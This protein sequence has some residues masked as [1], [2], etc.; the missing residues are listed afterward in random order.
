MN[1]PLRENIVSCVVRDANVKKRLPPLNS[2]ALILSTIVALLFL[3]LHPFNRY[4]HPNTYC[5]WCTEP[6]LCDRKFLFVI[7]SGRAGSTSLMT[8]LNAMPDVFVSGENNDTALIR[9]TFEKRAGRMCANLY[10]GKSSVACANTRRYELM[11]VQNWLWESN[12]PAAAYMRKRPS[13]VGF[14]EI[15]WTSQDVQFIKEAAPCSRFVLNMRRNSTSQAR[16]GFFAEQ[17]DAL[18]IVRETN[19]RVLR[20]SSIIELERMYK[21]DLED[22]STKRFN[23]L[24]SWLGRPSCVFQNVTHAHAH[25]SFE[26]VAASPCNNADSM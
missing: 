15:R 24:A 10:F 1:M 12:I 3:T 9:E 2:N 8:M 25:N 16:S 20:A 4:K 23:E 5:P 22:F 6:L 21:M 19:E 14:K 7:S 18:R 11:A 17:P 13:I 26:P